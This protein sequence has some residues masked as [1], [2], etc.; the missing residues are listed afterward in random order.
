MVTSSHNRQH[1]DVEQDRVSIRLHA[2][3]SLALV[4]ALAGTPAFAATVAVFPLEGGAGAPAY[5]GLGLGLAGMIT[6]DLVGAPGLTVVERQQIDTLLAE[7]R[8]GDQGFLDPK[9]A[10]KAGRGLG[11]E[12]VLVGSWTVVQ[13]NLALDARWVEV[14]T[15]RVLEGATATGPV[16]D[17]VTVEKQLVE[18]L[19][20]DLGSSLDPKSKR[21]FYSR[22]PTESF[23]AFTAWS[24]G[25]SKAQ[26]GEL[27]AARAAYEQALA[28]D[29]AFADALQARADM[30]SRLEALRAETRV[31]QDAARDA[32]F[33]QVL[34]ATVDPR[35]W[36]RTGPA[37]AEAVSGLPVR[38]AV[39]LEQGRPCERA[40]EMAAVF[41]NNPGA[42]ASVWR[43]YFAD[44]RTF[45]AAA[46]ARARALGWVP[47]TERLPDPSM[48]L[49]L[50][51]REIALFTDTESFLVHRLGAA[52]DRAAGWLSSIAACEGTTS[53][54][55][56][57]AT[58]RK[59]LDVLGLVQ[60]PS[61]DGLTL[62]DRLTIAR[63][64]LEG[65]Q[66]ALRADTR[67]ELDALIRGVPENDVRRT[68]RVALVDS[69]ARHADQE[70]A[71]NAHLLGYAPST[72][73]QLTQAIADR[74]RPFQ[75]EK[76]HCSSLAEQTWGYEAKRSLA[77][78]AEDDA[79]A[80]RPFHPASWAARMARTASALG[81][82]DERATV[83]TWPEAKSWA[84]R[85]A[86]QQHP[87]PPDPNACAAS[88]AG[89]L[90]LAALPDDSP[91]GSTLTSQV[92]SLGFTL[93]Q[94]RCLVE[95]LR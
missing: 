88:R 53:G 89:L 95:G 50:Y 63:A 67:A 58:W 69:L 83:S 25:L 70:A 65:D 38:W 13:E 44:F 60:T 43:P 2:H 92:L 51:E 26:Q 54:I 52:D 78:W 42:P 9:T 87:A 68:E 23:E 24:R 10:A 48:S 49:R 93:V 77:A 82:L 35:S 56:A 47:P 28:Q 16:A 72:L 61:A 64:W 34:S 81:C 4:A 75:A 76:A 20:A 39:L 55:L 57:L 46:E 18:N 94:L 32:L 37:T 80:K 3:R 84:I 7:I 27:D 62:G 31:S 15:G 90:Q 71:W 91:A 29:P 19:L 66:G 11:A 45:R 30:A 33:R 86:A 40:A 14:S 6:S 1:L 22:A 41:D 59:R 21:A 5:E 79:D 36:P 12:I 74:S 73:R 8:L 17:F 85:L